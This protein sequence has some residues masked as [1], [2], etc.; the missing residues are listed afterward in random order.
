METSFG[1]TFPAVP[2]VAKG[3]YYLLGYLESDKKLGKGHLKLKHGSKMT[4]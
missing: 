4:L 1:S 2:Q 3:L